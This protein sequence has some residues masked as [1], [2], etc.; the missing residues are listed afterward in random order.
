MPP[1]RIPVHERRYYEQVQRQVLFVLYSATQALRAEA[2]LRA[3]GVECA[4]IPIPRTLSSQCGVCLRVHIGDRLVAETILTESGTPISAIH[5]VDGWP[6][7][8]ADAEVRNYEQ[9][10]HAD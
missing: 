7:K 6:A 3:A 10:T 1:R 4:I 8:P 2:S 5:E 9:N